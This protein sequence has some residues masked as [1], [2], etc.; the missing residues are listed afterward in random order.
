MQDKE[1]NTDQTANALFAQ[2][3]DEIIHFFRRYF[4]EGKE[5][6][7]AEVMLRAD[8]LSKT[9]IRV[10]LQLYRMGVEQDFQPVFIAMNYIKPV[11]DEVTECMRTYETIG[12][13]IY[14]QF[15]LS[16]LTNEYENAY[17]KWIEST[18]GIELSDEAAEVLGQWSGVWQK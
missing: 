14:N 6:V 11:S 17:K 1:N 5:N 9:M 2:I 8:L 12:G 15:N 18:F 7:D 13:E 10:M 16:F 3:P 4:L